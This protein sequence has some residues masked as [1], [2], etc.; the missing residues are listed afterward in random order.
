MTKMK[1][2]P[3]DEAVE[4]AAMENSGKR[5]AEHVEALERFADEMADLKERMKERFALI[6][7]EGFDPKAVKILMKRRDEDE[8]DRQARLEFET[9][10]DVYVK[11]LGVADED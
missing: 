6:K 3:A 5:L 9:L 2:T 4:R 1:N 8:D 7:G 10:V 11:A